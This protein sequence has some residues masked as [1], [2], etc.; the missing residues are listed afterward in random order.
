MAASAE[1]QTATNFFGIGDSFLLWTRS[2]WSRHCCTRLL[3]LVRFY[4]G[5]EPLVKVNHVRCARA[6]CGAEHPPNPGPGHSHHC[7]DD[8][9]KHHRPPSFISWISTT[10]VTTCLG[11]VAT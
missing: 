5:S 9:V 11:A 8:D 10:F 3:T 4:A 2:N 1:R 6:I 7:R